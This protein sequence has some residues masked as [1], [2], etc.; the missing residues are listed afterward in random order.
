MSM[1]S[2]PAGVVVVLEDEAYTAALL[3]RLVRHSG[4]EP[5]VYGG[6]A[7]ARAALTAPD[8][9]AVLVDVVLDDGE[10]EEVLRF[11]AEHRIDATVA[12]VSGQD[13]GYLKQLTDEGRRLGLNMVDPLSKPINATKI[14]NTLRASR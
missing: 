14:G 4:F 5:V 9:K 6:F 1:S 7:A 10:T 13:T 11:L 12:V 2:E 8:V 3:S